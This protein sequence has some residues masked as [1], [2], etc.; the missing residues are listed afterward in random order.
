MAKIDLD[1]LIRTVDNAVVRYRIQMF[2]FKA[3]EKELIARAVR[4]KTSLPD[5][6][7]RKRWQAE[8]HLCAA[9]NIAS[10]LKE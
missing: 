8:Q 7:W 1:E 10:A 2:E 5:N 3:E 4:D 9:Q 6:Y